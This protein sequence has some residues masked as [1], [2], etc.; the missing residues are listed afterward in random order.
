MKP[1]K[2][3]NLQLLWLIT[4]FALTLIAGIAYWHYYQPGD[5]ASPNQKI[6][7]LIY[8]FGVMGGTGGILACISGIGIALKSAQGKI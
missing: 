3:N 7:A 1:T 4:C 5:G 8:A 6:K 2:K